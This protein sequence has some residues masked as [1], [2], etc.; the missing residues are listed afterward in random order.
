MK[1]YIFFLILLLSLITIFLNPKSIYY[2]FEDEINRESK[3]HFIIIPKE[4]NSYWNLI[5]DSIVKEGLTQDVS[6]SVLE[7]NYY[8]Q[9]NHIDLINRAIESNCDGIISYASNNED[10]EIIINKSIDK[11]IP[12]IVIDE[13]CL[14]SKR[15]SYIGINHYQTGQMMAEK[16]ASQL[17]FSG[18]VGIVLN[19]TENSLRLTGIHDFFKKYPSIKIQDIAYMDES[20]VNTY[21]IIEDMV[22]ENKYL[23]AIICND[24]Y[25][26]YLAAQVLVRQNKV[27]QIK[28]IGMGDLQGIRR[29]LKKDVISGV[30]IKDPEN[31]GSSALNTMLKIKE[32]EFVE[33]AIFNELKYIEGK[34]IEDE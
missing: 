13:D 7:S 30:F 3:Y 31:I 11:S 25:S 27:G 4:K 6:I 12:F 15:N 16:I 8:D 24:E 22:I 26:T 19:N 18:N 1:K 20:K 29:F 10:Y 5:I 9:E 21:K 14:K 32:N 28:I 33:N 2:S 17:N 34:D 23:N